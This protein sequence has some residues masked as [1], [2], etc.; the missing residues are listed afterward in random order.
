MKFEILYLNISKDD[1]RTRTERYAET[2]K[3]EKQKQS[4]VNEW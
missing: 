4:S 2:R 3:N 1:R